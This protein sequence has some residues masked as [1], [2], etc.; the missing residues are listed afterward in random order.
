MNGTDSF[1][2]HCEGSARSY[3]HITM[4]IKLNAWVKREGMYSADNNG[5]G[6]KEITHSSVF[7]MVIHQPIPCD[8]IY[9]HRTSMADMTYSHRGGVYN[10]MSKNSSQSP[11]LRTDPSFIF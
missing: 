6:D 3:G 11:S 4:K 10:P 8:T 2:V 7:I 5:H 1:E 9:N